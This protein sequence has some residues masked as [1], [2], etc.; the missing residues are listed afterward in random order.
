MR[1]A[2]VALIA[3]SATGCVG[4]A[5]YA[6]LEAQ[7]NQAVQERA[8]MEAKLKSCKEGMTRLKNQFK[9]K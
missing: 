5:K 7:Y 8:D 6:A 4:K 9:G 1:Y 2:I 3:L